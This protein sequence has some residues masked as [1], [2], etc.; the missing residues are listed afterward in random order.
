M[1]GNGAITGALQINGGIVDV[2]G[3]T[4][5]R[6]AGPVM[7]NSGAD[8][9]GP[10]TLATTGTVTVNGAEIDGG[11]VWLNSGTV[12][13][14]GAINDD[15]IFST[16]SAA[17]SVTNQAGGTFDILSDG[18]SVFASAGAAP[19][20]FAN[21]GLLKTGG[22]GVVVFDAT[23]SSAGTVTATTGTLELD[24]GGTL[25]GT[26]GGS[27]TGL[28]QLG[29][30][31]TSVGFVTNSS[32]AV[33]DAGSK[34]AASLAGGVTWTDS[35]AISD[36]G[37]VVLGN[38][39]G[40]ADLIIAAGATLDFTSDDGGVLSGGSNLLSNA[41]LIAKTGGTGISIIGVGFTNTGTV[42]VASGTLKLGGGVG[43]SGRL[44][45]EAAGTLEL[46]SGAVA[47][48]NTI[49]FAGV[50]AT[51]RIDTNSTFTKPIIGLGA[52]SRIDLTAASSVTTAVN[53][54]TLVVTPAGECAELR[55]H[56][57][58]GRPGRHHRRRRRHRNRRQ[59]R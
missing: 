51:L 38:A 42:E 32:L 1:T 45:V 50:G 12:R 26:I 33:L 41:G 57:Q 35:G 49:A 28:V 55:L 34:T 11:L 8:V 15:T 37:R 54:N 24:A 30:G 3:G 2:R 14:S 52:G 53:G 23:L 19:S 29:D 27:G 40:T 36:G 47:G 39:S 9:L 7:W 56:L 43:G 13:D 18:F 59:P 31:A 6:L 46:H 5:L 25:D 48:N 22:T 58:P 4:S 17:N 16:S 20:T 10:G 21:A 44:Q